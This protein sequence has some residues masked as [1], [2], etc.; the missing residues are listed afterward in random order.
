MICQ[1][2][3]LGKIANSFIWHQVFQSYYQYK[4]IYTQNFNNVILSKFSTDDPDYIENWLDKKINRMSSE[5]RAKFYNLSDARSSGFEEG[6]NCE[7]Y[8]STFNYHYLPF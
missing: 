3:Y 5:N 4:F 8:G 2:R 1:I 6:K 7:I